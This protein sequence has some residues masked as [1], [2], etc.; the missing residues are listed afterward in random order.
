MK[1]KCQHISLSGF[2]WYE[3]GKMTKLQPLHCNACGKTAEEMDAERKSQ[4]TE[5][6]IK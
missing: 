5:K 4:P 2:N 6:E 1:P 3:N